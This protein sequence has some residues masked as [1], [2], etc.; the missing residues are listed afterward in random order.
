MKQFWQEALLMQTEPYEHTV[1]WNKHNSRNRLRPDVV[2]SSRPISLRQRKHVIGVDCRRGIQI[3]RGTASEPQ[4]C[5][6]VEIARFEPTAPLFGAP[7]EM[8]SLE[9]HWEFWHQKTRVPGP[10]YG[11]ANVILSLA[12]FVQLRL[13]TDGRTDGHTMTANT[14]LP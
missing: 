6:L 5:S 1:N 8:I 3:W 7:F 11:V 10:S 14:A 4:S 9:F 2:D 12:I 13:V